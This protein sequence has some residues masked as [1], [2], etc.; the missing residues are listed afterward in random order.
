MCSSRSAPA[1]R[2]PVGWSSPR[3]PGARPIRLA[4][5]VA[6][7]VTA[8][9][10]IAQAGG[11]A[12]TCEVPPDVWVEGDARQLER[13]LLNLVGNAVKFTPPGGR[14]AVTAAERRTGGV[15]L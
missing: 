14:V 2:P 4:E 8:M 13:A 15:Q 3:A 11:L 12:L 5:L 10:P 9:E 6:A 7:V 1:P